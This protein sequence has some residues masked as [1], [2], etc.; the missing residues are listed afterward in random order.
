MKKISLD[1]IMSA[2][3]E[4]KHI[5]FK[6]DFNSLEDGAWCE[7]IKDIVALA[8][9]G[10]GAI[11]VGLKSNGEISGK[12][13]S[14]FLG[15][16]PSHFTDKIEK[17]T[18]NQFS[19]FEMERTEKNGKTL[20]LFYIGKSEMPLVFIKPGTY[21]AEKGK[22]NTAFS[23]GTVYFRH[24]A[25]SEPANS[26]D[27]RDFVNCAVENIR[28][29]WL[30]NI[31]KVVKAP[32]GHQVKILPPVVVESQDPNAMPIRIVNDESAPAYRKLNPDITHPFRQ[33]EVI[34]Q[35]NQRIK[36]KKVTSYDILAIRKIFSI[37]ESKPEFF[38]KSKFA[39]PQYS[40]QFIDWL[41][42]EVYKDPSFFDKA[43]AEL[44][45]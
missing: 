16:D 20:G 22:Q 12:D 37:N 40:S 4:S 31:R 18:G 9:S 28:K 14:A 44:K 43:R 10:G 27:L 39:S 13:I 19:D 29:E 23:K 8:N 34:T 45:K 6:E 38:H 33:K 3:K 32:S 26:N 24:G 25:K 1:K 21:S 30:G 2:Q 5:E 17:Y 15:I 36:N 11:V 41:S 7:L 42:Q 35:L